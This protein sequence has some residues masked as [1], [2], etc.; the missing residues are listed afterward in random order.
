[1]DRVRTRLRRAAS[2]LSLVLAACLA[3]VV[4][5]VDFG[6]TSCSGVKRVVYPF[7]PSEGYLRASGWWK[8]IPRETPGEAPD[9]DLDDLPPPRRRP[10]GP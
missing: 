10:R 2:L 3:D 8:E 4:R 5:S 6:P 1:M 7:A 9:V